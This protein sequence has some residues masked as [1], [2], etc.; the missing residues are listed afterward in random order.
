MSAL[1][2]EIK[3][4]DVMI[5]KRIKEAREIIGYRSNEV[6]DYLDITKDQYSRIEC[7]RSRCKS[8]YLF[9]LSSYL[10]VSVDYLLFGEE[11]TKIEYEIS[12]LLND[13]SL[14]MLR[15]IKEMIEIWIKNGWK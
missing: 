13:K 11:K 4:N 10:N 8:E 2:K 6:A 9:Y 14:K 12:N 15:A 1:E 7:G 5:G 3:M